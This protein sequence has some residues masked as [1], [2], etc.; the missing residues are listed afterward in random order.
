[1]TPAELEEIANVR[2]LPPLQISGPIMPEVRVPAPNPLALLQGQQAAG[3][4]PETR[5]AA[6]RWIDGEQGEEPSVLPGSEPRSGGPGEEP[7]VL[8]GSD[9]GPSNR[10]DLSPSPDPRDAPVLGR[11]RSHLPT[12]QFA[13]FE[14]AQGTVIEASRDAASAAVS[15]ASTIRRV[16]GADPGLSSEAQK[17]KLKRAEELE[18]FAERRTSELDKHKERSKQRRSA[19]L[20][21]Q[22]AISTGQRVPPR[23]YK[24][25]KFAMQ[26]SEDRQ[27]EALQSKGKLL[28]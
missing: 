16:Q 10:V 14:L 25:L 4:V 8:P 23:I 18:Q 22:N 3:E 6:E 17:T 12:G 20:V 27:L 5:S 1:M 2:S 9:P 15:T 7:S 28:L 13:A 24:A 19:Q 11:D 21:K 26:C